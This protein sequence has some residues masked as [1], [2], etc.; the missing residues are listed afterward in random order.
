LKTLNVIG[1]GRVGQTLAALLHQHGVCVVQDLYSRTYA[2][3]EQAANFVGAGRVASALAD[4][5][6]AD[7]WLISVPDGQ[8][9]EVSAQL[10]AAQGEAMRGAVVWHNSGFLS[11]EALAPLQ[12]VGASTA[13]VHPVLSFATPASAV[14]Q[15][16][17]TLCGLEGQPKALAVLHPWVA[18]IGGQG[19]EI[20]TAKKPLY[21]AAAVF[22]SNFTVV[23]QGVAQ[24]AWRESGVPAELLAPL[25]HALL[26][27][28]VANVAKLGPAEALTGPAARGDTAVVQRQAEVVKAWHP[29][30]GEAYELLSDM[31]TRLKRTGRTQS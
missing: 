28:S 23:L 15:F 4:M 3:A 11:A 1:C 25:T 26:Q 13:S 8:I 22:C 9:A 10:A 19:F 29:Q 18:A 12:A 20:E 17:G 14:A 31:A 27:S 16:A 2:S 21:H 7:V 6:A 30:A 5:R 24:E